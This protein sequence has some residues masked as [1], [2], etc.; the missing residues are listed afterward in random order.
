MSTLDLRREVRRARP[1]AIDLAG[2]REEDVEAARTNWTNR[3]VSEHAS[4]RVFGSLL[5]QMMRAGLPED[6]IH[7]VA[8]MAQQE[9]DHARLCARV[10]AS[11]G[12][13]PRAE[14]PQLEDVPQHEDVSPLCAVLRNVVSI[15]CCSETVAVALVAAERELAGPEPVRA[16]L[17]AILRDEIKHSRFGWRLLARLAPDLSADDRA[18]L[19]D[20]LV[21]AFQHQLEF[22]GALYSMSCA[23]PAGLAIGAPHGRSSFCVFVETME[24]VVVPGLERHGLAAQEAW[25]SVVAARSA[26]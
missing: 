23:E 19:D 2:V 9:L 20:Y 4:A 6:E 24:S 3:M 10:L 13:T 25:A 14:L 16:V 5:A 21:D 22:Y 12:G 17:D 11:L 18:S 8:E 15:G 7:R 1:L 26:T